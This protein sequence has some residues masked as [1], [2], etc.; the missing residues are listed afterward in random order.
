MKVKPPPSKTLNLMAMKNSPTARYAIKSATLKAVC[1]RGSASRIASLK[2]K[3]LPIWKA[4][5]IFTKT[6]VIS[7]LKW[8]MRKYCQTLMTKPNWTWKFRW[9]RDSATVSDRWILQVIYWMC[10]LKKSMIWTK[11]KRVNGMSAIKW[12]AWCVMCNLRWVTMA[13]HIPRLK[14]SRVQTLQRA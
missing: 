5:V 3:C 13:M 8:P 2:T 14:Y 9:M 6:V 4:W 11:S 7:I 10:L 1:L 12:W